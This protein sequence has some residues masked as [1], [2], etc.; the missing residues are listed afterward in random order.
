MM[1][2]ER[3]YFS[4]CTPVWGPER[5]QKVREAAVAVAGTGGLGCTVAE[6]LVRSG[7]GRI[8][9]I[10]KGR[11]DIPDLNRQILYSMDDVGKVKVEAAAGKLREISTFTEVVPVVREIVGP[12]D[13][14]VLLRDMKCSVVVDC[15]DN[16]P[17][18]FALEAGMPEGMS[19]VHGGVERDYGQITTVVRGKTP[20]LTELYSDTAS[21]APGVSVT[22]PVVVTA[23]GIMAQEVLNVLW[24]SPSLQG[25]LLVVEFSDFSFFYIPLH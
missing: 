4:R 12:G 25:R 21:S 9:L 10:D 15:L 19:L 13:V 23:G 2:E 11:V 14:A 6:I 1:A 3:E 22:P 16:F 5:T 7:I 17:G 18:R 24:G 20:T 8:V